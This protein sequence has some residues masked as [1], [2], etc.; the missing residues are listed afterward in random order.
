MR[1]TILN[2]LFVGLLSLTLCGGITFAAQR[3]KPTPDTDK[4]AGKTM[5][6]TGCLEKG[7]EPGEYAIKDTDGKMYGLRSKNVKMADHLNHKVTVTGKMMQNDKEKNKEG[8]DHMDV[9]NL[10]MVSTTCQ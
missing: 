9:T 1:S 3:E 8:H 4:D 7:D 2:G 5:M 6:V 10:K